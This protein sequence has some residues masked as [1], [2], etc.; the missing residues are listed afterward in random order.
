MRISTSYFSIPAILKI[1]FI[2][3][4]FFRFFLFA[5]SFI[6]KIPSFPILKNS[7]HPVYFLLL[8][9]SRFL[10]RFVLLSCEART[11]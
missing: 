9:L 5:S 1:P 4:I 7:V 8:S 10:R 2:L 3:S 11:R 6:A